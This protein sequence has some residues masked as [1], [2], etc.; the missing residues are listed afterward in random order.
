[1]FLEIVNIQQAE[2]LHRLGFDWRTEHE[3][4]FE[5]RLVSKGIMKAPTV[6]LA[7]QWMRERFPNVAAGVNPIEAGKRIF[8]IPRIVKK[9]EIQ[10]IVNTHFTEYITAEGALL[11]LFLES[12]N[13]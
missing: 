11:D 6:A 4:N 2:K 9:G 1:M 5:G 10:S 8:Y 13:E 12:V 3:Y 7:L